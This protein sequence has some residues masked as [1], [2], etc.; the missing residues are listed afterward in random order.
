M[1]RRSVLAAGVVLGGGVVTVPMSAWAAPAP[2]LSAAD[3]AGARRLFT[4]GS[5]MRFDE[6]LPLLLTA[7]E[8]SIEQGPAGAALAA[9]VW[10]LASQ[11]AV[12]QG[13]T[14]AGGTYAEQAGAAARRSGNPVVLAAAARA[15]ATPLRRTGHTDEALLLLHEAYAH[16]TAGSR[17]AAAELEAAGLVALTAAYTAAQAHRPGAARDFVAQAEEDTLRLARHPH[18][19]DRPR[20]LTA[21]Q[22][23]LYRIGIH[24]HLGDPD[25]ALTHA[26]RLRPA[27]LP[28]AERRA[29]AA[30]DTARALL[31]VG[32]AAGAFAQLRLVELAAPLEARRPSARRLTDRVAELRPDLPSLSDYAQ[33]TAAPS[34]PRIR[35]LSPMTAATDKPT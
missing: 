29:R 9:D 4:A 35:R 34:D 32:D 24:R 18:T 6:V 1:K 10:A 3:V 15:A 11:R 13:R 12:K 23:V 30:T 20:E 21:D 16:L 31:D 8:H 22:C 14:T 33:R 19:A 27:Q 26:R 7:A 2:R 25:T 17:P 28:T 5:Y